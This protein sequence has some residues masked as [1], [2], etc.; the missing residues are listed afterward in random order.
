M[1]HLRILSLSLLVEYPPKNRINS[2]NNPPVVFCRKS[3]VMGVRNVC[4]FS[5]L[6]CP[7]FFSFPHVSFSLILFHSAIL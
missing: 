6:I 5:I 1:K 2:I 7:Q 3:D 4:Y